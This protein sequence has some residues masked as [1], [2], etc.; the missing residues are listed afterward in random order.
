MRIVNDVAL[1]MNLLSKLESTFCISWS[2]SS[3]PAEN[4]LAGGNGYLI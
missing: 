4:R 2:V 1:A 3:V